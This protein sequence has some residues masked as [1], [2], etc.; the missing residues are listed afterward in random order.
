[1]EML[2]HDLRFAGRTLLKAPG[3]SILIIVSIALGVAANV[4]VFSIANGLL[5]GI[6]PIKD[7][8]RM[9]MFSEGKSFSYLDY[10]DLSEQTQD[11]FEGGVVAHFP[12]I[13]AS[14]G[15]RG[16]PERVWGQAASG[17]YF[18]VLGNT[19]AVGRPILPN[20]DQTAA[21]NHVVVLSDKLWRRRFGTDPTV[22]NR[23]VALNGKRYTIVGITQPGF[24][25]SDR[26]IVA[27]F[28]VPLAVADEIMPDLAAS[29]G[30][31]TKRDNSWV[32]LGAR[33]RPGMTRDKA[34]AALNVAKTRLDQRYRPNEKSHDPITLQSA[35]G[36]IAGS[37]TPAYTLLAVLMVVVGLVLLVACA[38][39][40]NLLLAR[41]TGRQKEMAIRLSMGASRKRLIRQLLIE[42][43]L[44]SLCGAVAGFIMAA[45]ATRAVSRFQLPLPLPIVFDFNVDMRVAAFALGLSL[46]TALLFGLAPAL[47]AS[48]TDLVSSLKDG[49]NHSGRMGSAGLRNTLVLVQVAL[50]LVL[51]ATAGLFLRSLGNASSIDIGFN[52]N[53]VLML[54]VDPKLQNYS[55][56]QTVQFLS[57][58][59]ERVSALPGVRSMS[60]VGTVPLSLGATENGFETNAINNHPKLYVN[61]NENAVG[62]NYFQT[63][64]I[65]LL[66]GRD[67]RPQAGEEHSAILNETMAVN[68]FPGQDPLG[69]ELHHGSE[70]YTVIGIARNS[71]LRTI[72]ETPDNAIYLS[73]NALP[74]KATSFFGTTILVKT[75][76][77]PRELTANVRDQVAALDANM[78]VFNIESMQEHVD[79]SLLLPR[80]AALLLG[81]FGAVGLTL[82]AV[83]LFGVLSYSVR[84]RTH[85]IGVRMALGAKPHAILSMILRQGMLLTA[86]GLAIGLV[87]ALI[88]GRLAASILYGTGGSDPLTFA[89]VSAVLLGTAA[90]AIVIPAVR[91]SRV[92]PTTALRC[93]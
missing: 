2:V 57:R 12:I 28:W 53:N 90:I 13:P 33:L 88:L 44:L 46:L 35:G 92:E 17:N 29:G 18:S 55:R 68:L 6:L 71:K 27:E 69:R 22:L 61:A 73:L 51:L 24:Y 80:I 26:G 34:A 3:L 19:I 82:A 83:G 58:M 23:E 31:R 78:A 30:V 9:V 47:R 87:I 66:R 32:I 70:S 81:L 37:V 75:A 85:E 52:P 48:R 76:S 45:I 77:E 74:E 43:L 91:A 49:P 42:S 41:A 40:A 89:L 62:S 65:P 38:N 56:D 8:E 93:E 50:S 16:E 15:G 59:R 67:F 25:G 79:K 5:W 64:Q 54:S 36:L 10:L 14:I 60:F 11:V 21:E 20:D 63:L 7:P 1:M 39:V 86:A 4:T 84:L 72:G